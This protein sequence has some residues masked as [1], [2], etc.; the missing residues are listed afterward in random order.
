MRQTDYMEIKQHAAKIQ[1]V[2][3]EIKKEIKQ[4]FETNDNENT[5]IQNV[6]DAAKVVLRGTFIAIQDLLKKK[7][8]PRKNSNRQP[9][10]PPKRIRKRRLNKT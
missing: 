1:W 6:W 4:Y 8:K 2:N 9:N 7:K 3:E 5:T 10:L